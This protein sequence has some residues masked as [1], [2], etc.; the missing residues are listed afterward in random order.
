MDMLK[1]EW[2]SIIIII[3]LIVITILIFNLRGQ[4]DRL[5]A[6]NAKLADTLE[7]MEGVIIGIDSGV[8]EINKKIKNMEGQVDYIR[9]RVRRR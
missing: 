6:Q 9:N 7:T 8:V 1:K 5:Q 2:K 3:I 4:F